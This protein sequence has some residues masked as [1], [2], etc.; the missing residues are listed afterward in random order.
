VAKDKR[1][2]NS[3]VYTCQGQRIG[4]SAGLAVERIW[5][6]KAIAQHQLPAE[7][8]PARARVGDRDC[9]GLTSV[10]EPGVDTS[11]SGRPGPVHGAGILASAA[12]RCVAG[13]LGTGQVTARKAGTMTDG[14]SLRGRVAGAA[15][16]RYGP[17]VAA[18]DAPPMNLQ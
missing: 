10:G 15:L 9:P 1:A 7:P 5:K 17:R 6:A 16:R 3:G 4:T 14:T 13:S 8:L 11:T 18:L 12:A 2:R